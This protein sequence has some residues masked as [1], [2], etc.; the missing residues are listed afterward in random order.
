VKIFFP[1]SGSGSGSTKIY[2]FRF[3][4][5]GKQTIFSYNKYP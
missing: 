3:R 5:T 4:N 2:R 1:G